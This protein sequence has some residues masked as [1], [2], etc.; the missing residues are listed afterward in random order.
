MRWSSRDST[1]HCHRTGPPQAGIMGWG[2]LRQEVVGLCHVKEQAVLLGDPS[3]RPKPTG[4]ATSGGRVRTHS[5][6]PHCT[7]AWKWQGAPQAVRGPNALGDAEPARAGSRRPRAKRGVFAFRGCWNAVPKLGDLQQQERTVPHPGGQ[8]PNQGASGALLPPR[9]LRENPAL[10]LPARGVGL[11]SWVSLAFGCISPA[12]CPS[13]PCVCVLTW[14]S[15]CVCL[16][17]G[18][19]FPFA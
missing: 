16:P 18:P 10:P 17:R 7:E 15:F 19:T 8:S 9:A 11:R 12:R 6:V 13:C 5:L 14:F 4:Y 2:S 3:E 1:E